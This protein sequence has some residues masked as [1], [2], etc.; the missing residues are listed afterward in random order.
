[1]T[2]RTG[3]WSVFPIGYT[4]WA[5]RSPTEHVYQNRYMVRDSNASVKKVAG[6]KYISFLRGQE[7]AAA[8]DKYKGFRADT[9]VFD[10]F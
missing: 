6:V 5:A 10:T 3:R 9:I 1:M 7:G 8:Y 4:M 2:M